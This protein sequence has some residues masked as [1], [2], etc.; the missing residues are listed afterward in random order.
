[1]GSINVFTVLAATLRSCPLPLRMETSFLSSR[2]QP[3]NAMQIQSTEHIVNHYSGSHYCVDEEKN[4]Y[5]I[6]SHEV[7]HN[8]GCRGYD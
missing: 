5:E 8:N 2:L 6:L 7:V 4:P 3:L 1:M